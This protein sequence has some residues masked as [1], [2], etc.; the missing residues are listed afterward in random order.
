MVSEDKLREIRDRV[1]IEDLARDYNVVLIPAGSR[2]KALCPFHREKTPSFHLHPD[3]QYFKCFGCDASGDVFSFVQRAES[4]T[5][6]ESIE[7]LARKAGVSLEGHR[8]A[9]GGTQRNEKNRLFEVLELARDFYHHLLLKDS[10][11]EAARQY[12]H[13]RGILPESWERFQLGYS[14]DAWTDLCDLARSRQVPADLLEKAGLARA[15]SGGGSSGRYDYFRNR[16]MFPIADGLKRVIGFGARTL[17][18]D[19]PKYLNTPKTPVFDKSQVLYGL[20]QARE[21]ILAE[22]AIAVVEGYTDVIMAHQAGLKNFVASLGTAFTAQNARQLKRLAPRVEMV[23]DGDQAGQSAAERS[24]DL[25]VEEDLDVRI[26]SVVNGKDPCDAI[27]ELGAESFREKL[28]G[29]SVGIFEFK[30]S[31]TVGSLEE[32]RD[33]ASARARA[34]DEVL[35][36]LLRIPNPVTRQLHVGDLAEKLGIA[37][38]GVRQRLAFLE[39]QDTRRQE[40]RRSGESDGGAMAPGLAGQ[41]PSEAEAAAGGARAPANGPGLEETILECLLASPALAA[42]RLESLPEGFFRDPACLRIV[43]ALR[44]RLEA[45]DPAAGRQQI[46]R[47]LVGQPEAVQL[48]VRI[49]ER[50]DE[51]ER[52]RGSGQPDASYFDPEERWRRCLSDVRRQER[53]KRRGDLERRKVLARDRGDRE[54]LLQA[55][56]ET[57]RLLREIHLESR[58]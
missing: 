36:L 39:R 43:T 24:L 26:Y 11:A 42:G 4:V 38:D 51:V 2:F 35:G 15:R 37:A 50:L 18:D 30:W 41:A 55:E 47:D 40:Y 58:Q 48:A 13:A 46:L 10:R 12:L 14:P 8:G 7:L 28:Q 29:E 53:Q 21:A 17:G 3:H 27:Q 20:P 34:L 44:T 56:Q 31:R 49:L 5:F 57:Y 33:G 45:G 22:K 32:G 52:M 19:Q 1:R 6:P 54:A 9:G 23:F 25:L 16:I